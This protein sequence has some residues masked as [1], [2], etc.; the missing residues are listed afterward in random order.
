MHFTCCFEQAY[1]LGTSTCIKCKMSAKNKC[2]R[3][4]KVMYCS[5][6]CQQGHWKEHKIWCVEV[7][8]AKL[9]EQ[10]ILKKKVQAAKKRAQEKAEEKRKCKV[11]R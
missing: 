11:V 1:S 7:E 4:Q 8:Q 2:S 10:E 6:E 9:T 3:C 5:K